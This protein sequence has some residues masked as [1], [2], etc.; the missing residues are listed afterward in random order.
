MAKH[1]DIIIS[2]AGMAGLSLAYRAVKQGVWSNKSI[3]I[4]DKSE[5]QENDKTWCFWDSDESPFEEV[6]HRKWDNMLFFTNSGRKI[7]LD[8][9]RYKYKM[10]RSIDFYQHTL[11]YLKSQPNISFLYSEIDRFKQANNKAIVVA[12]DDEYSADY[13]FNSVLGKP[14]LRANDTYL[15]QHF[16]GKFIES[17]EL[18]LNPN[19]IHLMDFRT[20]QKHGCTFVYLLPTSKNSALVEYTLFSDK[21]LD[22]EEYDI[23]LDIYINEIL[24]V[25]DYKTNEEEFGI[26]PMTDY[27]FARKNGRII[28]I[29]TAG[30][31]TRGSTGYTF[32][33]TQ[34]TITNIIESYEKTGSPLGAKEH[35]G[36]KDRLYDSTMLQVL[37]KGEYEGHQLFADMF[38]KVPAHI[39]FDFLN[40]ESKLRQDIKV[41]NSL[42]PV[43]FPTPFIKALMR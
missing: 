14:N 19:Q 41:I 9:E 10:I 43:H 13:I 20:S 30:G 37:A 40:S 4:I 8:T 26:I 16:K 15:L 12:R 35:I 2:G 18:N 34:Q 27:K 7:E 17:D 1:Y 29:G 23:N 6:V 24:G 33:N 21:L 38:S 11:S 3:L 5:K 31:D 22:T 42:S 28:N 32:Y 25:N 39:I 36:S